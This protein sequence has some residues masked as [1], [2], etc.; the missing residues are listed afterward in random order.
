MPSGRADD[1][2][3]LGRGL[4][5][6]VG[7]ERDLFVDSFEATRDDFAHWMGALPTPRGFLIEA[8]QNAPK[9]GAWPAYADFYEA[10]EF[11]QRR[12]M[13]LLTVGEWLYAAA[14]ARGNR[15][16]WGRLFQ[17][18]VANTLELGL[19]RPLAVG[20]FENGRSPF[21]CYDMLGNAA[22]WVEG[23]APNSRDH[24]VRAMD[25]DLRT[26]A[27]GSYLGRARPLFEI[28]RRLGVAYLC[29]S[30]PPHTRGPDIGVRCAVDVREYLRRHAGEWGAHRARLVACG[31]RWGPYAV[32]LLEAL[33]SEAGAPTAIRWLLEGARR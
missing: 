3:G 10:Q 13:R 29:E 2:F 5:G 17:S 24:D 9:R 19:R 18:S 32:P 6:L 16:P 15:Y 30:L 31:E 4:A 21:G 8:A 23:R 25:S 33:R 1:S 28:D 26:V 12:G 11:A 20:T 7:T 27:G 22:E 14:G